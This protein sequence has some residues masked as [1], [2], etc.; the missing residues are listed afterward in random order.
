[1]SDLSIR[2]KAWIELYKDNGLVTDWYIRS[3]GDVLAALGFDVEYV[4]GC[5]HVGDPKRDLYFVSECKSAAILVIRGCKHYIYWAQGIAPE[6]DYLRFNN[7]FRRMAFNFCEKLA[8][9]RADRVFMVSD[10]MLRHFET[11]YHLNLENKT[12]VAPCCNESLHSDSF[13]EPG[14]YD[15]PVFVYAGGLSK[16]Q[17]IDE[18]L[19]LFS[20]IQGV[21]PAAELLFYT[22]DVDHA[23]ELI[24]AHGLKNVSVDC[25]KQG[26]LPAALARAKYGFVIRNNTAVNRVATPTKISTYMSNGV[27]PVV[28]SCV[29]GFADASRVLEHVI[30]CKD[31]DMMAAIV[32]ME[33]CAISA[34]C[35]LREYQS[36]FDEYFD[37]GKKRDAIR[38]F[39]A[40]MAGDMEC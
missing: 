25:K 2:R 39:L 22:W 27:I 26:E 18:M 11:K 29:E 16:Y 21:L 17:C 20:K 19:E 37:L 38:E 13:L 24:S 32:K 14:K 28:S 30:C 15:H 3:I 23:K 8:L 5:A 4:D 9:R 6:E 10:A 36:F 34:E 12:F 31:S 7:K 35:V 1:M 40:P 33:D